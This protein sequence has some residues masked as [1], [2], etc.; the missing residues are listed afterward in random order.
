MK[1]W[2]TEN[3]K[4]LDEALKGWNKFS[5]QE[6]HK[7]A[8]S[9]GASEFEL[10]SLKKFVDRLHAEN[11]CGFSDQQRLEIIASHPRGED[12]TDGIEAA[13]RTYIEC[14]EFEQNLK[15]EAEIVALCVRLDEKLKQ[16]E[17]TFYLIEEKFRTLRVALDPIATR[18]DRYRRP[19]DNARQDTRNGFMEKLLSEWLCAGG[20][21]GGADSPVI[22]FFRA[23]WPHPLLRHRPSNDA[24]V[25]WVYKHERTPFGIVR[26][27]LQ[28]HDRLN[29]A[30]DE[31]E[32]SCA[33][34][35]LQKY[36]SRHEE[37]IR[38]LFAESRV[39]KRPLS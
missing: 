28:R 27:L 23:A 14:V 26:G 12:V 8:V 32:R 30:R 13:A 25:Q 22:A 5:D 36:E 33:A 7:L 2:T 6:K 18:V 37:R 19:K 17:S 24:I 39:K 10:T 21:L 34:R 31:L 29:A 4:R 35:E 1:E 16:F 3:S 11:W 20:Q 15:Q 38:E 9:L